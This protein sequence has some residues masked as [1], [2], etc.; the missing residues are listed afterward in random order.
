MTSYTA[1]KKSFSN[2]MMNTE[3]HIQT[4]N[5]H[6]TMSSIQHELWTMLPIHH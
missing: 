5:N 2:N 3:Y 1:D 6:E 4:D